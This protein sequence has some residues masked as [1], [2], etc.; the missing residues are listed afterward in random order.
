[1]LQIKEKHVYPPLAQCNR[2][3][4]GTQLIYLNPFKVYQGFYYFVDTLY[5]MLP[6]APP[7]EPSVYSCACAS[8]PFRNLLHAPATPKT[9]PSMVWWVSLSL[10]ASVD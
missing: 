6:L 5:I 8:I 1:M 4:G 2:V 3:V 9:H 7:A 10:T